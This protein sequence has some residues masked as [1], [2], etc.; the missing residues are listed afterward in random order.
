MIYS[1]READR[2][3]IVLLFDYK[4]KNNFHQKVSVLGV[5]S[6]VIAVSDSV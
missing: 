1:K 3:G 2:G 4:Y 6:A 5:V